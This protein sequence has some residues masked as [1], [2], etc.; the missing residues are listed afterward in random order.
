M[1]GAAPQN[2]STAAKWLRNPI[3]ITAT[4]LSTVAGAFRIAGVSSILIADLLLIVGV[5]IVITLEVGC[6][7]WIKNTGRYS[8]SIILCTAFISGAT[9]A[10]LALVIETLTRQQTVQTPIPAPPTPI[11]APAPSPPPSSGP[12]LRVVKYDVQLLRVGEP[13]TIRMYLNN[14]GSSSITLYGGSHSSFVEELPRDFDERKTLETRLWA[15]A[16]KY[17][18]AKDRPLKF[19]TL[20]TF[21]DLM[22]EQPLSQDQ[23]NRLAKGSVMYMITILRDRRGEAVITSCV[24][25][26]PAGGN[27]FF[28]VDHNSP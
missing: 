4:V 19:Q 5:W 22:S 12:V 14:S 6:S 17:N 27:L 10:R 16:E 11:R 2:E 3:L 18:V 1:G 15:E 25:T 13:L 20:V 23:I 8:G 28:C 24:H 9:S 26:D 21:A 7:K